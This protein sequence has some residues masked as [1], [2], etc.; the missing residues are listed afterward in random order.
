MQTNQATETTTTHQESQSDTG[1]ISLPEI[2]TKA[3]WVVGVAQAHGECF[4]RVSPC[5]WSTGKERAKGKGRGS[6]ERE[7]GRLPKLNADDVTELSS[8]WTKRGMVSLGCLILPD[9]NSRLK[10]P[11]WIHIR[12]TEGLKGRTRGLER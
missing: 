11:E 8:G 3:A 7:G 12:K 1:N 4:A 5:A 10:G 6:R 2:Q 9:S